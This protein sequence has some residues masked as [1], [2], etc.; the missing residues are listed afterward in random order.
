MADP[1]ATG[2]MALHRGPG[3]VA[4]TYFAGGGGGGTPLRVIRSRP[5]V[6]TGWAGEQPIVQASNVID[7]QLSD[8]AEP[9]AGDVLE[10]AGG[11]RLVLAGEPMLDAEGI[12]WR[13]GAEP[14]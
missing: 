14:E 13:C 10:L 2:L 4:A 5:D 6:E 12:S 1:F 11:E 7:I 9:L 3:S 8:V